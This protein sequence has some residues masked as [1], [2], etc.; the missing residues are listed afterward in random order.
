M[1]SSSTGNIVLGG[2]PWCN[3]KN[4]EKNVQNNCIENMQIFKRHELTVI[5]SK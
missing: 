2:S 1:D 5:D 4:G 3:K